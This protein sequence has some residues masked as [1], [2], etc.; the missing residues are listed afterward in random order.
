MT[1]NWFTAAYLNVGVHFNKANGVMTLSFINPFNL[2]D[3]IVLTDIKP[4]NDFGEDEQML[5][6][7]ICQEIAKSRCLLDI[8]KDLVFISYDELFGWANAFSGDLGGAWD[9][10]RECYSN[11]LN[12]LARKRNSVRAGHWQ[13]ESFNHI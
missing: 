4:E 6:L 13:L 12:D 1:D 8:G 3:V 2:K 9:V 11:E 5:Y 7:G 10:I